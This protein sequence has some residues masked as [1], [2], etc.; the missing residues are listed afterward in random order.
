MRILNWLN[1]NRR[2]FAIQHSAF[3]ALNRSSIDVYFAY[4]KFIDRHSYQIYTHIVDAATTDG[5]DVCACVRVC[6]AA[7]KPEH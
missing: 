2:L 6:N 3:C 7:F 1:G 5:D 4:L